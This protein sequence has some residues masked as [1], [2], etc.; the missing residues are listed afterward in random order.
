ME[1]F[2]VMCRSGERVLTETVFLS[3]DVWEIKRR[4]RENYGLDLSNAKTLI[5]GV[6]VPDEHLLVAS[7][8]LVFKKSKPPP[9]GYLCYKC[10][11][12]GHFNRDCP[13]KNASPQKRLAVRLACPLCT[14]GLINPVH[15]PCCLVTFCSNCVAYF[16]HSK[17]PVCPAC[18]H[19]PLASSDFRPNPCLETRHIREQEQL[20]LR[21]EE[22]KETEDREK[23]REQTREQTREKTSNL[24]DILNA[25]KNLSQ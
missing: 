10:R 9:P 2:Q 19:G 17:R 22:E 20:Q 25:L 16:L 15:S 5:D 14:Q 24:A 23:T 12:P 6:P 7:C 18:L 21:Q 8:F 13:H 11:E 1:Y 3:A 4:L